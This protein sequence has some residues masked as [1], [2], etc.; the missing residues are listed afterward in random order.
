MK[1]S[2]AKKDELSKE[3]EGAGAPQPRPLMEIPLPPMTRANVSAIIRGLNTGID[4]VALNTMLSYIPKRL[5]NES[6]TINSMLRKLIRT[7]GIV[8]DDNQMMIK[9]VLSSIQGTTTP[10]DM[11]KPQQQ[12]S[13]AILMLAY[14]TAINS[15]GISPEIAHV[16]LT[17]SCCTPLACL[18]SGN[19]MPKR[20]SF[21]YKCTDRRQRSFKSQY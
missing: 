18:V 7:L 17:H 2:E 20:C 21:R 12:Q 5:P 11:T 16:F 3:S 13:L 1:M 14:Y 10:V 15:N 6:L 9:I 19:Y 8:F 4:E